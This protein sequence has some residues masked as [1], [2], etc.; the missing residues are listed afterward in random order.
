M[1]VAVFRIS[2]TAQSSFPPI[3][4]HCYELKAVERFKFLLVFWPGNLKG[5]GHFEERG[6]DMKLILEW[7]LK[8]WHN[9]SGWIK[10]AQDGSQLRKLVNTVTNLQ[11][12]WKERCFVLADR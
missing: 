10:L 3:E 5:R 9:I 4:R 8:K 11:I 1:K 7:I 6:A 12:P 2:C